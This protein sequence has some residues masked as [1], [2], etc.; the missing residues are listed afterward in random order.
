MAERAYEMMSDITF[1]K[2][3]K[4]SGEES[5]ELKKTPAME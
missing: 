5:D 2:I 1:D 3:K 4:D